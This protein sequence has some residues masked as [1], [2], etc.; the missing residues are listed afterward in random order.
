MKKEKLHNPSKASSPAS[1]GFS[2]LEL[3]MAALLFTVIG[4]SIV[5]LFTRSQKVFVSQQ[6]LVSAQQNARKA[7]DYITG[8]IGLAG[9][10][11]ASPQLFQTVMHRDPLV[12][13]NYPVDNPMTSAFADFGSFN[14]VSNPIDSTNVFMKGCFRKV[15]GALS[16][17]FSIPK[18]STSFVPT[19]QT[20]RISQ[21]AGAFEDGDQ[22]MMY[23]TNP[24]LAIDFFWVY[25]TISS[26]ATVSSTPP[27]IDATI[28]FA[29]GTIPGTGPLAGYSFGSGTMIYKVETREFRLN[30]DILEVSDNGNPYETLI[31]HV[32][33]LSFRYFDSSNTEIASPVSTLRDC[34]R[35]QTVQIQ[36]TAQ[37]VNNDMQTKQPL[38]VTYSSTAT[39]RN[40]QFWH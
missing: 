18:G 30:G 27:Q 15:Y 36:V 35:I 14:P 5:T 13:G 2:M 17:G 20:L 3:L 31:D 24:D 23:D 8:T 22:V 37:S 6:Q 26:V 34:A 7:L 39:P 29:D 4:S 19:T 11:V 16:A 12:P 25:G 32:N 21:V 33:Q 38:R 1:R 10:G 9:Y 28:L 40:F